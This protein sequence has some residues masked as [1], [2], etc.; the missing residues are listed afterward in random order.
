MRVYIFLY[1]LA[2]HDSLSFYICMYSLSLTFIVSVELDGFY[3]SFCIIVCEFG[4]IFQSPLLLPH[5]T[6]VLVIPPNIPVFS[7]P[8][9]TWI[10]RSIL[11]KKRVNRTICTAIYMT[12]NKLDAS[13]SSFFITHMILE[14][15]REIQLE[16]EKQRVSANFWLIHLISLMRFCFQRSFPVNRVN[17]VR[18][19]FIE[20]GFEDTRSTIKLIHFAPNT[21]YHMLYH[22][23]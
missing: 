2:T 9:N 11:T 13:P 5:F 15:I 23:K 6:T 3:V 4:R 22:L 12:L 18:K 16:I 7:F 14:V 19:F 1:F 21:N 8:V 20:K 17:V 10:L